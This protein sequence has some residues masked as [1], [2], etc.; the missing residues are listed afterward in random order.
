MLGCSVCLHLLIQSRASS[1]WH[2][3]WAAGF[4]AWGLEG[5]LNPGK[6]HPTKVVHNNLPPHN[7]V[8]INNN[9]HAISYVPIVFPLCV[10][11]I[12]TS[13]IGNCSLLVLF[14][15]FY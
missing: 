4:T 2:V 15:L 7:S 9:K 5:F 8:F 1:S 3:E 10:C 14:R 6:K 11:Q 13:P 12:K